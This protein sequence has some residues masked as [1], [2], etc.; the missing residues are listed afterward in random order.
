M[1]AVR[2]GSAS[3]VSQLLQAQSVVNCV[4]HSCRT[5]LHIAASQISRTTLVETLLA[6]NTDPNLRDRRGFTPL[7]VASM[8]SRS[9]VVAL[10]LDAKADSNARDVD[11][12]TPLHVAAREGNVATVEILVSRGG[13]IFAQDRVGRNSL[14]IAFNNE[15]EE[16][17][18]ILWLHWSKL[19][20]S[21]YMAALD[22]RR[23]EEL[24]L[25]T[26]KEIYT[27]E[28]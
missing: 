20:G 27:K 15:K 16:T 1:Y 17:V 3:I 19:D 22:P 5:S 4:N 7:H 18:R 23:I 8:F 13:D 28:K 6:H 14:D 9:T 2:H 24:P 21:T 11:G 25:D 26:L 10:L 12:Q